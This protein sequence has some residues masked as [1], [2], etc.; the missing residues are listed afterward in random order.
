MEPLTKAGIKVYTALGNHELYAYTDSDFTLTN[1]QE[2]QREFTDNPSN[3]PK[4]YERLVYSFTSP[5]GDAFFAVLDPYY[6]TTPT[7][8]ADLTG[9]IDSTQMDWLLSQLA[10]TK[11]TH[12]FLCIHTPYY[13]VMG[14][15]SPD[16]T[17]Y[18]KL[19]SYLDNY[20]FDMY[21]CGHD[22]LYS[23]KTIDS[24]ILPDPQ[25]KPEVGPWKNNVVQLLNGTCGAVVQGGLT[26]YVNRTL[27]HVFNDPDT[28]YFSVVDIDGKKVTVNS[29][30]GNTGDY[31]I[32][33][34]FT[35]TPKALAGVDLLL[36]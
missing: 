1:Q 29:Y 30:K 15:N 25:I 4:G 34:S 24:S 17:S 6:M 28:Y 11:A 19:W 21:L 10:Q 5:G 26:P 12:K 14:P 8:P 22:H 18:T 31:T 33:D 27:W 35:L 9:N 32:F 23:R 16:E 7:A 2:Y 3:G 36:Q 13:H 20:R